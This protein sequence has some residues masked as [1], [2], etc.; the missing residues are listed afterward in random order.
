MGREGV[1]RARVSADLRR[2][3]DREQRAGPSKILLASLRPV[4]ERR[5]RGGGPALRARAGTAGRPPSQL[6]AGQGGGSAQLLTVS[7]SAAVLDPGTAGDFGAR[8]VSVERRDGVAVR[9][10]VVS[11]RGTP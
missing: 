4:P 10:G 8:H 1:G 7:L 5:A 6:A 3:L 2:D 9:C 11:I